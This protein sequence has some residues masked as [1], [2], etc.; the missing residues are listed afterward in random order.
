MAQLPLLIFLGLAVTSPPREVH[1]Y[2]APFFQAAKAA[3][4]NKSADP[5][6]RI[7]AIPELVTRNAT[8]AREL[9]AG[10]LND[11]NAKVQRAAAEWLS[12]YGDRRALDWE[13]RCLDSPGCPEFPYSAVRLLGNSRDRRYAAAIRGRVTRAFQ[14][15]RMQRG[16]WDG[17]AE[18]RAML[19]YGVIALA[20]MGR[21]EDVDLIVEVVTARPGSEF[22]DAL[23]YIDDRRTRNILWSAYRGLIGA[24]TCSRAGLGVPALV[25][26]SRL[27][28]EKAV[29]ALTEI[30]R[31]KGTPPDP[32]ESTFPSLCAD[33]A[34]AFRALRPRDAENFGDV[35]FEIAGQQPEGPGTFEAWRALGVMK[36]K[37]FASRVL[38]LAV[39]RRHWNLVS[40]DVL[41]S[42]VIA[43]DPELYDD[44]WSAYDD[45]QVLG[46]QIGKRTLVKEGLGYLLFSGTGQWTGD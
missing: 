39:S 20:R 4:L 34:Q 32:W 27:G 6:A 8:E 24:P 9:I 33:R 44:F 3:I 40:R 36:P 46:T 15:G 2:D 38:K 45:V 42:V 17:S 43:L 41:N 12:A 23:S 10:A 18:D 7:R 21:Q 25:P 5:D 26:L 11:S 28:E 13:A 1:D 19:K 22:L 31:G 14:S 16:T 37:A 30:L 29:E 35:I